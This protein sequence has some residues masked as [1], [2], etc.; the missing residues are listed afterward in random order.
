MH[1][2]PTSL[3]TILLVTSIESI[4]STGEPCQESNNKLDPNSHKFLSD[5]GPID[6]CNSTTQ[7]CDLKGCRTDEF[8]FGYSSEDLMPELCKD[9]ERDISPSYKNINLK[10]FTF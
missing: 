7:T 5:C 2:I 3:I 10:S 8:P 9:G 4:L 1:S 6:F